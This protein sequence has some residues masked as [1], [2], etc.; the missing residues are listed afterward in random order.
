MERYSKLT[1]WLKNP[2]LIF[3]SFEQIEEI[4]GN[5][6]PDAA[7]KYRPWW[8]N[9]KG[10]ASRQC[11]AWMEAGWEVDRVDLNARIVRFR[12]V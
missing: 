12:K 2:R 1:E 11:S 5:K 8:G 10:N 9:E 7:T 3:L 6:L 4:I